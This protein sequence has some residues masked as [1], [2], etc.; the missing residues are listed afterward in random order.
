MTRSKRHLLTKRYNRCYTGHLIEVRPKITSGS[1]KA[2]I[3]F[4]FRLYVTL[5]QPFWSGNVQ[6]LFFFRLELKILY[7]TLMWSVKFHSMRICNHNAYDDH[8]SGY[9]FHPSIPDVRPKGKMWSRKS[10][11]C[12]EK[13]IIEDQHQL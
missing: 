4:T 7:S 10:G 13:K 1:R 9:E 12:P 8:S 5:F 6:K 11:S 2:E 3:A